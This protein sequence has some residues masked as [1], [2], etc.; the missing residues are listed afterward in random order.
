MENTV[1]AAVAAAAAASGS[2]NDIAKKS[3]SKLNVTCGCVLDWV[4]ERACVSASV[5]A[6]VLHAIR[7]EYTYIFNIIFNS[8]IR[9]SKVQYVICYGSVCIAIKLRALLFQC[10]SCVNSKMPF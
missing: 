5:C 2:I 1:S 6:L 7:I 10:Y 4:S 3:S 8:V 9:H